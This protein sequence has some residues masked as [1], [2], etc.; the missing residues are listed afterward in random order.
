M[1]V[2]D[3]PRKRKFK[4]IATRSYQIPT[5]VYRVMYMWREGRRGD[6]II[7]THKFPPTVHFFYS[8]IIK[9][10]PLHCTRIVRQTNFRGIE[11][12]KEK[13]KKG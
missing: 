11:G 9:H 1:S 4:N 5:H 12:E 3:Q 13:I 8:T 7:Q 2:F 10:I 6:R